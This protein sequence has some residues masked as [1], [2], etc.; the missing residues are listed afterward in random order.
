MWI[1]FRCSRVVLETVEKLKAIGHELVSFRLPDPEK[2]ASLFYRSVMPYGASYMLQL[3]SNEVIP[4][5][6]QQ[7]VFL[8]KIPYVLRS[9][10]S[11]FLWYIS[12]PLSIIA[13][14]Y[15]NNLATL[16]RTHELTEQYIEEVCDIVFFY[17]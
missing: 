15:V 4:P 11:Y 2:A 3:F 16:Q 1:S 6:L 5:A 10:A 13:G 12:K 14:S 7:F 8:L 17:L 9:I